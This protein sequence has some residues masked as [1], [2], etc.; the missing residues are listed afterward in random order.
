MKEQCNIKDRGKVKVSVMDRIR[1]KDWKQKT[2]AF[3]INIFA[4]TWEWTQNED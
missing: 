1:V 3:I 4:S 2:I